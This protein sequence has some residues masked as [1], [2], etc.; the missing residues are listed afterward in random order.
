MTKKVKVLLGI[1]SILPLITAFVVLG[2]F[3]YAEFNTQSWSD[4]DL[5]LFIIAILVANIFY[6]MSLIIFII[7]I[8]KNEKVPK[9]LQIVW[10]L[11]FLFFGYYVFPVYW[12]LY[13]WRDKRGGERK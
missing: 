9:N 6:Y 13:I 4:A 10:L 2:L 11:L 8:F 5:L 12:Y 1:L 3:V 7:N